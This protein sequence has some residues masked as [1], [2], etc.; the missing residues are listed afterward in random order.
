MFDRDAKT[1]AGLS[2]IVR[3]ALTAALSWYKFPDLYQHFR[4]S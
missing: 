3:A 1:T 2:E 4:A